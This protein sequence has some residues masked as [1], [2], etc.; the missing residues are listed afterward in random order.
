[1]SERF[2]T[3]NGTAVGSSARSNDRVTQAYAQLAGDVP[4]V[5]RY[6]TQANADVIGN[7]PPSK[8]YFTQVCVQIFS[9]RT[10]MYGFTNVILSD[11]FPD[12]ITYNSVGSTRFAT[13]VIVVD[14]GDDQ[15]VGRWSQP[16]MEYDIAYGV[17]TMEQLMALIG[18]FRAMRGRLY[19]FCYQDNV[20]YTSSVPVA[21]EARTAPPITPTDQFIATGDG[22]TYQFQLIKT[23]A[24]FSQSQVRTIYRP[25]PGTVVIGING[26]VYSSW[27]VDDDTGIVTFNSPLSKTF[28]DPITKGALAAA[29]ATLTG[30]PGDFT[31]FKPYVDRQVLLSGF[32]QSVNNIPLGVAVGARRRRKARHGHRCRLCRRDHAQRRGQGHRQARLLQSSDDRAL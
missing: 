20:D 30:A 7:T 16:L 25:Q 8:R 28:A 9:T 23:Y 29:V 10:P 4:N 17:R 21:Y 1:M 15:R 32:A 24:A 18:F 26:S 31:A 5:K 13:D 11:V 12:D 14:F 19:A 3:A 27:T 2:T 6:F 22:E